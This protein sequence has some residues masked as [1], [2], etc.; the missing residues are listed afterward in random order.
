M[1]QP[2]LRDDGQVVTLDLHGISVAEAVRLADAVVRESSKLGRTSVR[3][4]HGSSTTSRLYQNRTIKNVLHTWIDERKASL[5]VTAVLKLED[6]CLLSL[7]VSATPSATR[8][9]LSHFLD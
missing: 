2:S 8:L 7:P 4:V 1:S 9:S 5:K 3:I 6:M